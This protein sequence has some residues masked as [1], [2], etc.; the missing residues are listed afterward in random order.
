MLCQQAG[1]CHMIV[2]QVD[3]VAEPESTQ[4]HELILMLLYSDGYIGLVLE[5]QD[6]SKVAE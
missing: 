3:R 2:C 5:P 6:E 4:W 1:Q